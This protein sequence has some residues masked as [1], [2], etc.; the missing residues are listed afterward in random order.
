MSRRNFP[1]TVDQLLAE[2]QKAQKAGLGK[3]YV[4]LSNDEEGNGYHECYFGIQ[5]ASETADGCC[6]VPFDLPL[7]N[8]VTLG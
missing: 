8:C 4:L 5:N 6:D 3:Q 7:E 1:L 2:C